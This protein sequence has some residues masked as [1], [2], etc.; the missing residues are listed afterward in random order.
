[1]TF[2]YLFFNMAESCVWLLSSW[3]Q[4]LS[5]ALAFGLVGV[6]GG[7]AFSMIIFG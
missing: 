1:M 7:R 4:R 5:I 6:K 2:W 3:I